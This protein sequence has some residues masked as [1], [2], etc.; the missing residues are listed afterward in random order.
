M[1]KIAK[2][3]LILDV[4]LLERKMNHLCHHQYVIEVHVVQNALLY[5]IEEGFYITRLEEDSLDREHL[6]DR[7]VVS[8]FYVVAFESAV[9]LQDVWLDSGLREVRLDLFD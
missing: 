7:K 9:D 5:V 4:T 2:V 1:A 3:Q 8:V 6:A